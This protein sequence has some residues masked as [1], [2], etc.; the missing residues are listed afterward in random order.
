MVLED[1]G[2][3]APSALLRPDVL[4]GAG[5]SG[6]PVV[7]MP[8]GNT[9]LM[10]D[11]NNE[12]GLRHMVEIV[13]NLVS[14][15]RPLSGFSYVADGDGWR[16]FP[17]RDE[18]TVED[19]RQFNTQWL[20]KIYDNQKAEI[21]AV[22]QKSLNEDNFEL[23][24]IDWLFALPVSVT[25]VENKERVFTACPWGKDSELLLPESDYVFFVDFEGEDEDGCIVAWEEVRRAFGRLMTPV[26]LNPE[27]YYVTESP[28]DEE[29]KRV[30]TEFD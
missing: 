10:A 16:H 7:M 2:G 11:S 18:E 26:G 20:A 15:K 4:A 14:E 28:E 8:R 5:I 29:L 13:W 12:E 21:E 27:R 22:Q 6:T 25:L 1:A 24:E 23:M 3:F 19:L 9:L 30:K 17:S